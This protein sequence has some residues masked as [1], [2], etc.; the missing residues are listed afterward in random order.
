[1]DGHERAAGEPGDGSLRA[2]EADAALMD[3]HNGRDPVA[4]Q[5]EAAEADAALMDGHRSDGALDCGT[6]YAAE[7]DAALMDGH[8]RLMCV[9]QL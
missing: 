7:A 5:V 3:G 6:I 4:R 9:L 1:M 2:A 8:L